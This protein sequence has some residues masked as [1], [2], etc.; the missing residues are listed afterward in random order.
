MEL[1]VSLCLLEALE[2]AGYFN[3]WRETD[4][5]RGN[6]FF[7]GVTDVAVP[8]DGYVYATDTSRGLMIFREKP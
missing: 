4:P 7:E 3:T 2:R 1:R 6:T 8:G 5:G